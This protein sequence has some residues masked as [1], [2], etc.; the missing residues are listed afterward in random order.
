MSKVIVTKEKITDIA[1][2]I[3]EKTSSTAK[4]SLSDM[5][6]AIR[7]IQGGGGSQDETLKSIYISNPPNK[8]QYNVGD[9]FDASGM[10]VS[11][12]FESKNFEFVI[13]VD[14]YSVSPTY[15]L[16]VNDKNIVVSY[17]FGEIT[18]TTTVPITV[19]DE[20]MKKYT[21]NVTIEGASDSYP[22][23]N[24]IF[25]LNNGNELNT[26]RKIFNAVKSEVGNFVNMPAT[27]IYDIGK[28]NVPITEMRVNDYFSAITLIANGAMNISYNDE[29]N[30][31]V[32][33]LVTQNY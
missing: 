6:T 20:S 26:L 17:T 33:D 21:H 31:T 13:N 16:S 29:A 4:M 1:D 27:G 8:T 32:T 23:S 3:R 15:P 19:I 18:K 5:P 10:N 2:A 14:N 7:N 22:T 28:T 12:R 11:A 9:V 30:Y 25:T 24:V